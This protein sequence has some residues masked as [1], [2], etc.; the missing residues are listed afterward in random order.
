MNPMHEKIDGDLLDLIEGKLSPEEAAQV[1]AWL[2]ADPKLAEQVTGMVQDRQALRRAPKVTAPPGLAEGVLARLE[3]GSLLTGFE[4]DLGA[5]ATNVW[6]MRLAIAALLAVM[7]GGFGYVVYEAV[8]THKGPWNDWANSK[9]AGNVDQKKAE[10]V[11]EIGPLASAE[12]RKD[13]D[14]SRRPQQKLP[15]A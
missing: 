11:T 14:Q 8:S 15:C 6:R 5:S 7:V 4:Q 1:R 10:T 13:S 9:I 3:R 2:V 12:H